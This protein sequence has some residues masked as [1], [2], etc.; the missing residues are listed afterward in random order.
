MTAPDAPTP[1]A[2]LAGA[3]V[4]TDLV[5][6]A[7]EWQSNTV[8]S[9]IQYG[10][11]KIT[12][13]SADLSAVQAGHRLVIAEDQ[14][15]NPENTG[16]LYIVS[17]DD[18]ANTMIIRTTKRLDNSLDET[19]ETGAAKVINSGSSIQA[20][21]LS[22]QQAGF[23]EGE[24]PNVANFNWKLN[25]HDLIMAYLLG[26]EGW[27]AVT[28]DTAAAANKKYIA[29]SAS[30]L[31][32]TLPASP[33]IGQF[34]RFATQG[35]GGWKLSLNGSQVLRT[36][37]STAYAAAVPVQSS[38]YAAIELVY[39]GSDVFQQASHEGTITYGSAGFGYIAGGNTGAEVATIDKFTY[40]TLAR[41]ASGATLDNT[42]DFQ[43]AGT[44]ISGT[45]KGYFVGQYTGSASTDNIDDMNFSNDA[46]ARIAA[47]LSSARYGVFAGASS[48]Y[49]YMVGGNT[50]SYVA[51][52][53]RLLLSNDTRSSAA[54]ALD[55]AQSDGASVQSST[56]L[57]VSGGKTTGD[58]VVDVI[59]ELLFSTEVTTNAG[60]TLPAVKSYQCGM[61][62]PL[63]G[64]IAGGDN[65]G[66]QSAA[67]VKLTYSTS[68][69]ASHS[70]SLS[71]AKYA[72]AAT[73]S[74]VAGYANGG[75]TGSPS[76]VIEEFSFVADTSQVI[77]ATLSSSRYLSQG[78]TNVAGN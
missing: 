6:T 10:L 56:K 45:V 65:V 25:Q 49:G 67:A 63:Y 74:Y 64:I 61:S 73:Y 38:G 14:M 23:A 59:D 30:R 13:N 35:T 62:G 43:G 48:T 46:S 76:N 18:A 29:N 52:A 27:A 78:V 12:V 32:F 60:H 21:S 1:W 57:F 22:K 9:R 34:F 33:T 55:A 11:I 19:G 42:R 47:T 70:A 41:S 69:A 54:Q 16:N 68:T 24:K 15:D 40:A 50:G 72:M 26:G 77:S 5:V 17:A 3:D 36:T 28:T 53:D 31:I 8:D 2:S 51:T 75:S 7:A 20:P 37:G 71:A 4:V 39:T 58:T 44:G 66:T